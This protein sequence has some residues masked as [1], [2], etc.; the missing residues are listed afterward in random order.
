MDKRFDFFKEQYYFE[1]TRKGQL[2]SYLAIPI[3]F[4][5]AIFTAFAFFVLNLK[6]L[7]VGYLFYCFILLFLVSIV[8][9]SM[10]ANHLIRS[11]KGLKY[12]YIPEPL[13]LFDFEK[14]YA[15][16]LMDINDY[17]E[18]KIDDKFFSELKK[19]IVSTTDKNRANNNFRANEI[20][21]ANHNTLYAIIIL[22][23]A[24][25]PF[26]ICKYQT[27]SDKIDYKPINIY[28]YER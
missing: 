20:L 7:K 8:F 28:Y 5:T 27:E 17:S 26:F 13:K 12:G 2:G 14:K 22:I 18:E 3:G 9:A 10:A 25:I 1:L 21:K 15:K 23:L 16:Y 24:S 19:S 11:F 6:E 4:L